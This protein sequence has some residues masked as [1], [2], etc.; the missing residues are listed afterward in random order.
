[1]SCQCWQGRRAMKRVAACSSRA[2][3]RWS[4]LLSYCIN[5][6]VCARVYDECYG[7]NGTKQDGLM[8]S[9]LKAKLH[10]ARMTKL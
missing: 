3:V 4:S 9:L 10:R 1:M 6:A 8:C 2:Y 5:L 7:E